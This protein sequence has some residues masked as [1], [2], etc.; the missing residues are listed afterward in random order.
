MPEALW[1]LLGLQLRG[2]LRYLG[3]SLRT[4]RGALLA[5]V[6]LTV[7]V[8]W[9]LTL[10]A[11]PSAS[12][13]PPDQL[14]RYGPPLL[15]VYCLLNLLLSSGEKAIYFSP[16]EV[17]FLFSGPFTRRQVLAY[18]ILLTLLIGVP[19]TLVM[20]A[21]VRVRGA[22]V[23]PSFLAVLLL[24][25]FMQMF[26]MAL[27]LLATAV[28]ARAY[29]RGRRLALA[30]LLVLAAAA[31]LHAAGPPSGWRLRELAE[32]ALDSPLGQK[33]L[34][35]LGWFFELWLARDFWPDLVLYGLLGL[36]VD[37][38]LAGLVLAL[39]AQYRE[40]AAAS[41]ARIYARLQ[42][43]RGRS[44]AGEESA[45]GGKVRWSLPSLPWWGGVGPI[46]WRQLV[47]ATRGLGRLLLLLVVLVLLLAGPLGLTSVGGGAPAE[48]LLVVL[49]SVVVWLTIFLTA[50]VPF[51]FRG[52]IDR[53]AALKTLPIPA[54][55]LAVGQLLTPVLLLSLI[56]W[57]ALAAGAA[58]A[59][60]DPGLV[61]V[62]AA[63][64]PP[65][66]FLLVALDNL[67]FL[68]FPTR[69]MAATPGDFQALGRNVVL[70]FAKLLGIFLV[71]GFCA[72]AVLITFL[73]TQNRWAAALAGWP[74]LAL[75][76]AALVPLIAWAFTAFDVGRD[77]PA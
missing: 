22:S 4:V 43:L 48:V 71:G 65:F 27:S 41:S 26:A 23:L 46:F 68:L 1:L 60:P 49:L 2:W 50:L 47:T 36:G 66:N 25:A 33:A 5:V 10:L 17:Y 16:A 62:C 75:A 35:P 6:G 77:T 64:V 24:Y 44:V 55:R 59:P 53:L 19:A 76:G 30:A 14:R 72:A 61:L 21:A 32:R 57:L 29:S 56:Q 28:G 18:K 42:R 7:F 67:L 40:A 58:L 20:T 70:M 13:I 39:D 73:L 15:L 38:A 51:D 34:L 74:V 12:G 31:A 63:Y 11:H 9:L 45:G 69:V 37:L 52:D 3:R 54:W 8:F